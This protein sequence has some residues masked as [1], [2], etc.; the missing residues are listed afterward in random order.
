MRWV[1]V[2]AAF[3]V[4]PLAELWAILSVGDTIGVLPTI[5][6]LLVDS[7]LGGLL[8]RSQGRGAWRRFV[9]ALQTGRVPSRELADGLLIVVGGA[10]L[11]TPGFLTDVAGVLL[12]IPPTRA[13][14]RRGLE[15]TI[16]RRL[17]AGLAGAARDARSEPGARSRG[18]GY[19]VEGT[20]TE[21]DGA[22]THGG[23]RRIRR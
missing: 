13:L 18:A 19:D 2:V 10:L 4:V 9:E 21:H 17:S 22:P 14:A 1:L 23:P 8:L 16:A 15:R 5:A 3:I 11:L 12:L 7:I 20:A 6:I